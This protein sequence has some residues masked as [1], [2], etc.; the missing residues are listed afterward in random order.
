MQVVRCLWESNVYVTHGS[1]IVIEVQRL[2]CVELFDFE[3]TQG[4]FLFIVDG[5]AIVEVRKH[6]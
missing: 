3:R 6:C 1:K 2:W 5:E 4:K